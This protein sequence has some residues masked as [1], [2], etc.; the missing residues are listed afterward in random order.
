ML[1]PV[2]LIGRDAKAFSQG[3]QGVWGFKQP[4]R[5]NQCVY[6]WPCCCGVAAQQLVQL[7]DVQRITPQAQH[8]Q[9]K[10]AAATAAASSMEQ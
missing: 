6:L 2:G 9:V 10:P 1:L 5:H 4:A 7:V 3:L 8:R